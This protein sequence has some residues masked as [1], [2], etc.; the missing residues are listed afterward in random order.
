[1]E[2]EPLDQTNLKNEVDATLG[3]DGGNF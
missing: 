2:R 1:V 3:G